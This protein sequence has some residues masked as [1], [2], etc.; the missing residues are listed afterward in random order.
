[1]ILAFSVT[2]PCQCDNVPIV[3]KYK[4]FFVNENAAGQNFIFG[5]DAGRETHKKTSE[6]E[7]YDV[8]RNNGGFVMRE[9]N[10][11]PCLFL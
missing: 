10:L 4:T 7:S 11:V 2:P 1:M 3:V 9:A 6:K 5:N 8:Q